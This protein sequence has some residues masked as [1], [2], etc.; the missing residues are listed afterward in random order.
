VVGALTLLVSASPAGAQTD[1]E[2]RADIAFDVGDFDVDLGDWTIDSVEVAGELVEG[3]AVTV[4]LADEDGIVVWTGTASFTPPVVRLPVDRVVAVRDVAEARLAQDLPVEVAGDVVQG[5]QAQVLSQG[6]GGGG[7]GEL[8]L[9]LVL[10]MFFL[11]IL[12]RTPLPSAVS[13][14]WTR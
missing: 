14:R 5:R 9:S 2:R 12:F 4:E 8:A 13:E 3:E 7:S 11:A 6:A 10:A 1:E